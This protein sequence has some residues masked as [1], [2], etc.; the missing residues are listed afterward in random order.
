MCSAGGSRKTSCMRW[1]RGGAWSCKGQCGISGPFNG[2]HMHA[3]AACH[4]RPWSHAGLR[5]T[6]RRPRCSITSASGR[7]ACWATAVPAAASTCRPVR[8]SDTRV[9]APA[10]SDS[11]SEPPSSS[12][13][14]SLPELCPPMPELSSSTSSSLP[15]AASGACSRCRAGPPPPGCAGVT[16]SRAHA[17]AFLGRSGTSSSLW[18]PLNILQEGGSSTGALAVTSV[19]PLQS[20]RAHCSGAL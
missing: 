5:R 20:C 13:S 17:G 14:Y 9:A 7:R 1:M 12:G 16:R 10:P 6:L 11:P 2:G 18:L 15:L 8:S 19:Q 4:S 3:G